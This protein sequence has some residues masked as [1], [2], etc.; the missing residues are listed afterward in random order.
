MSTAMVTDEVPPIEPLQPMPSRSGSRG[1]KA[2]GQTIVSRVLMQ[3]LNAGTGILTARLLLPTGRG[4][5]AAITLWSS[6]LAGLTTFGLPSALIYYVRS[7]PKQTSDLLVNGLVMSTLLSVVAAL[8]GVYF[9]PGWLHQYPLWAIRSAQWFLIITP[10]CSAASVLRGALE[11][12]GAFGTSNA[13]QLL[14]PLVTFAGLLLFLAAHRFN[15]F[16]AALAYIFAALPVFVLLGLRARHLMVQKVRLS[17][18]TSKLLLSYGLRSYGVDLLGTLALQVDQVIVVSFLRPA[19][20]GVYVVMLSLSRML[21]I[22]QGSVVMVLFPKATGMTPDVAVALTGRAAR[23]ST[24]ITGA[25]ALVV[26][27]LGPFLLR[28]FYG[29]EY[30]QSAMSLRLLLLEVTI[31]GCVFVLAQAFMAMGRPGVVTFLQA[32]GLALS[33]PLMLL[34]I[35][36]WG[37]TGAAASLLAS[38][39]VRFGFIYLCFPLV[40]KLPAPSLLPEREDF[41]ILRRALRRKASMQPA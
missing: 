41:E 14:N 13:S 28:I 11:A 37:I 32:V 3:G 10:L 30:A 23:V 20:L 8:V 24:L 29:A 33:V 9:M 18:D 39:I 12:S 36:R 5:L 6:F 27:L 31:S 21:N 40:L 38:T 22:F 7:R 1:V 34:L 35:P 2:I 4:E 26:A 19:D 25:C 17:L 16:T 15:T